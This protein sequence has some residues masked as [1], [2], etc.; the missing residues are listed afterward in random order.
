MS[1]LQCNKAPNLNIQLGQ[2]EMEPVPGSQMMER[3]KIAGGRGETEA[4]AWGIGEEGIR[5][6]MQL[7]K[8]SPCELAPGTAGDYQ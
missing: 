8:A 2:E 3:K 1:D 4:G 5:R 7:S 6:F